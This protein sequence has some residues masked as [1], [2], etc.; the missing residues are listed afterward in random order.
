M[1]VPDQLLLDAQVVASAFSREKC[2]EILHTHDH[3]TYQMEGV[4]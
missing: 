4:N 1:L 3:F 2:R